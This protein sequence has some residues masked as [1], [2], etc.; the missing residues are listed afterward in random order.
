MIPQEDVPV[1]GPWA[2]IKHAI[3]ESYA[4]RYLQILTSQPNLKFYYI[5]AFAGKGLGQ[6][7]GTERIIQG[8]PMRV[9]GLSS[10]FHGYYF[11]DDKPENIDS[12]KEKVDNDETVHF[13]CGDANQTLLN[14]LPKFTYESYSRVLLFL[15]PY[16][17]EVAWPV[18]ELA[19]KLGTVDFFLNFMT[20]DLNRRVLWHERD[21]VPQVHIDSAN[22]VFGTDLWQP[23]A[24]STNT[25]L[26]SEEFSTKND[27]RAV[28]KFYRERLKSVA[29]FQY[30][31]EPIAISNTAG[32]IMYH[33]YFGSQKEVANRVASFILK[34]FKNYR[35]DDV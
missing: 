34:K 24:Y 26:F 22:V 9:L 11:I 25:N 31:P 17:L 7:R 13:Y 2:E 3:L 21:R 16:K 8:S 1:V 4:Q 23:V 30:V 5:D 14:L 28:L 27:T 20:M 32:A 6:I 35:V 10:R 15:D 12:L 19:G 29:G 18:M 33:L